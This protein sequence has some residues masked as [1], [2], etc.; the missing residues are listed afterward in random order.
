MMPGATQQR[1]PG[2]DAVWAVEVTRHHAALD[3][4][5][6]TGCS[7][8]VVEQLCDRVVSDT[9]LRARRTSGSQP[10][11]FASRRLFG[12]EGPGWLLWQRWDEPPGRANITQVARPV[13]REPTLVGASSHLL[14]IGRK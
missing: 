6:M 10:P 4:E 8:V 2:G 1:R 11:V 7:W 12:V 13:E 3:P 5:L 14:V 9:A